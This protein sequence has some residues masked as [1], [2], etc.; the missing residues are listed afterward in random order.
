MDFKNVDFKH[1]NEQQIQELQDFLICEIKLDFKFA[2]KKALLDYILK[3]S[4]ERI[5]LGIDKAIN[6][7]I[8]YGMGKY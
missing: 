1:L 7:A 3:N 4:Q 8:E 2:A 6:P 5:R